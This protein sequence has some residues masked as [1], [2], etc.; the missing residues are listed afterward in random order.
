MD[1]PITELVLEYNTN[2]NPD[3]SLSLLTRLRKMLMHL[4]LYS[5]LPLKGSKSSNVTEC[6][7]INTF[8]VICHVL[9]T[10]FAKN[11]EGREDVTRNF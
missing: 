5:Q 8:T 4:F 3:V 9:E 10:E 1:Y 6:V 11:I 7:F 2:L